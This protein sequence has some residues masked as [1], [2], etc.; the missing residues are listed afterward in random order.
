MPRRILLP[1]SD[2]SRVAPVKVYGPDGTLLRI[3][4]AAALIARPAPM[5]KHGTVV[6][7]REDYPERGPKA[8]RWS[9]A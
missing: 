6:P 7:P 4:P 5:K 1:T 2:G 9:R 8:R 3:I